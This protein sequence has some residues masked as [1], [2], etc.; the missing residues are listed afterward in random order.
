MN[1]DADM[2]QHKVLNNKFTWSPQTSRFPGSPPPYPENDLKPALWLTRSGND[3]Y[4]VNSSKTKLEYITADTGGF[5]S[6]D[7]AAFEVTSTPLY[8]YEN[9][10]VG[11]AVKVDFYDDYYDLD[12][13]LQLKL[14]L[15]SPEL[16]TLEIF[17]PP[18]RVELKNLF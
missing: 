10:P 18:R 7:D 12:Y 9:V 11:Q 1:K 5:G 15:R 8:S 17:P 14:R 2:K 4:L 13:L 16:G 6:T 3:L